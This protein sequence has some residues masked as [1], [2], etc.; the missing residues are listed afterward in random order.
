MNIESL[1]YFA[2]IYK[3][4]GGEEKARFIKGEVALCVLK[5]HNMKAYG[6]VKV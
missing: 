3:K 6:V 4:V 1:K 2:S 5:H